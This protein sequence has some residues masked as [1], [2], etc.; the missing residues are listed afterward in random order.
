MSE[1]LTKLERRA[2]LTHLANVKDKILLVRNEHVI[3]D[4]DVAALYGVETRALNQAVKRNIDKFPSNYM[5]Q[6][7]KDEVGNLKSQNVTSSWGGT[8]V[9]PKAS[10]KKV[11]ICLLPF[12]KAGKL[13]K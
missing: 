8:R 3:I 1:K 11:C 13:W 7:M 12:S 4:A 2:P 5:F 10:Q 9:L 6:L